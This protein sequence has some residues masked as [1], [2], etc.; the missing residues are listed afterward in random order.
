MKEFSKIPSS[1]KSAANI[2]QRGSVSRVANMA[3]TAHM[4]D[5]PIYRKLE[6]YCPKNP[7]QIAISNNNCIS[8][9]LQQKKS[10][11]GS[12]PFKKKTVR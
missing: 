5:N 12:N 2:G 11:A 8:I 7:I 6:I 1:R 4:H 9:F 3:S 10:Q